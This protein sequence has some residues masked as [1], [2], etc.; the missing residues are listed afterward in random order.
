MVARGCPG[1]YHAWYFLNNPYQP[2][3]TSPQGIESGRGA[4]QGS[5]I[6]LVLTGALSSSL[7]GAA[8]ACDSS[9]KGSIRFM[10]VVA[11][12]LFVVGA[13]CSWVQTLVLRRKLKADTDR[14][15][16]PASYLFAIVCIP[17]LSAFAIL[18][19]AI[20]VLIVAAFTGNL[21]AP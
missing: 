21:S 12:A 7:L 4:T 9:D 15:N 8:L 17:F 13:F 11:L 20:G 10:V 19:L 2:S 14:I 3:R 18:L 6:L 16:W 1:R 5:T